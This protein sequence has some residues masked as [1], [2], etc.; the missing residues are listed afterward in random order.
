MSNQFLSPQNTGFLL[1]LACIAA[2]VAVLLAGVLVKQLRRMNQ[3]PLL[4]DQGAVMAVPPPL[5]AAGKVATW[6]CHPIDILGLLLM[7]GIFVSFGI[8]AVS[9]AGQDA[10]KMLNVSAL[11]ANIATFAV[12]VAGVYFIVHRRVKLAAWLG[13]RWREWPQYVWIGPVV[14][15]LMWGVMAWLQATGYIAWLEKVVGSSST[16]DAVALLRESTDPLSLGLMAFA[17]VIVAPLA[18]EVIFRGYLYPVAKSFGGAPVAIFFSALLFA[19]CHGNV[20]L[21]LP[22]FLLGILLALAYEW[23]GSLWAPISIHFFFNG[24]TVALQFALRAG[25][26]PEMPAS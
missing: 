10:K 23:T 24:A 1:L 3:V 16:Q 5:P 9:A 11:V 18:E 12:L 21:M 22:L 14:V 20:P 4:D 26:F 7:G 13:L 17:A 6:W 25:V 15:I 19:A 2:A 8:A